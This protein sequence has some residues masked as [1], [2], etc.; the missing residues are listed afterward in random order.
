MV[1]T[2]IRDVVRPYGQNG[3]A[4]I[5]DSPPAFVAACAGAMADDRVERQ[6][7][8]DAFLRQTSWDGTWTQISQLLDATFREQGQ[9]ARTA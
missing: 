6:R 5:A 4:R 3:L 2:S 1:S 9:P 8:A 7:V